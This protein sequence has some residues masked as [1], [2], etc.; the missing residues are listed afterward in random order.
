[1]PD[2]LRLAL[3]TLTVAR[4]RGPRQITRRTAGRAMELAPLVGLLLGLAAAV[5]LYVFRV[6]GD[7]RVPPLMPAALAVTALALL[8]RG[9]HLDGLADLVDGLGS[10]KDPAGARAVMKAPDLGPL[11]MAAVAL[12][13]I[14]QVSALLSCVEH[15][16]GT[17]S[18][19]T[20]VVVGRVAVLWA[21]T[22]TPAATDSG[23]GAMVARTA[24]RTVAGLWT[25]VVAL[26]AGIYAT[27][28]GD[29]I[30]S[31]HEQ[32][33]RTVLGVAVGLLLASAVRRHAVRRVG[34]LTGDVLGALCELATTGCLV[35]LASG[36]WGQ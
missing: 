7:F 28:D 24:H 27:V 26:G 16:R 25:L 11:G 8:T 17:A 31:D 20:S 22:T 2:A 13:L 32:F 12:T 23:L 35:V 4:V 9:L 33:L 18:L 21:C 1:M 30:G 29:S 3:T 14:V 36:A 5:V 19:V 15:G 6:L 10:Y 34:G